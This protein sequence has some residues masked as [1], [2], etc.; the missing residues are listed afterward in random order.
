MQPV[1]TQLILCKKTSVALGSVVGTGVSV[2]PLGKFDATNACVAVPLLKVPTARQPEGRQLTEFSCA[3]V[4]PR[5]SVM[6]LIT[7]EPDAFVATIADVEIPS[8]R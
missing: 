1:V 3:S 5:V 8:S 7:H 4:P 2:H 6:S